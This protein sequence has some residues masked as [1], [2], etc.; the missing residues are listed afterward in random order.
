MFCLLQFCV[1]SAGQSYT[2]KLTETQTAMMIRN[3]AKPPKDR[4]E[5]IQQAIGE[6]HFGEDPLLKEFGINP[7]NT[8]HKME[9]RVL[10]TPNLIYKD[11]VSKS[12]FSN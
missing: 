3:T 12:L 2:K 4:K 11:R 1:V 10:D 8:L 7:A 9:A 6:S 5:A